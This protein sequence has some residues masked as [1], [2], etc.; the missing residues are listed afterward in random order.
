MVKS[1]GLFKNLL[2]VA[3]LPDRL[4][5]TELP[6]NLN[7]QK[8]LPLA[9]V[10]AGL[11]AI[12][13]PLNLLSQQRFHHD[14]ALYA[15]WALEIASGKNVWLAETL[16]DKP[17]L[18]IYTLAGSMW[19]L[20]RTETAARL[21][22][23][24]A[25]AGL[26]GLT[27]W[28]GCKLYGAAVGLLAAWL[29]TVSPFTIL[30]APT[31]FTDPLL[32]ALVLASGVAAARGRAGWAGFWLGLAIA[33]KQQ[34]IFFGPLVVGLMI[35][36]GDR[37][38]V[39]GRRWQVAGGRSQVASGRSQVTGG[40]WQVPGD[41]W[42]VA[43]GRSQ[44]VS[45]R[46]QVTGG[47]WRASRFTLHAPRSSLHALRFMLHALLTFLLM[48]LLTL[49]PLFIWEAARHQS[50][51]LWQLSLANYGGLTA[52]AGGFSER[53]LG[54]LELLQFGTASPV[55]NTLFLVGLPLLLLYDL[56]QIR[57]TLSKKHHPSQPTNLPPV[58][59][60]QLTNQPTTPSYFDWLLFLFSLA[61]LLGHAWLSFQVWD[62]Y[63]LGLIPL[64]ALLLARV[65]LWP[66]SILKEHWLNR[67]PNFQSPA[68]F[69][70]ALLLGGLLITTMSRPVQ[71]AV[72]GRYP[73]GSHSQ[74][75]HGI[76]QIV[77]YLQ[78]HIGANHTLYHHWLGPHWRFYLWD[79]PYDLQYW[80]SP[81]ELA[82]RAKPGHLIAF[83]S[84]QS[85]T[86][87]RLALAGAGLELRELT[88][89]YHPL[90]YPTIILYQLEQ[91]S[92]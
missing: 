23:L 21:P 49:I 18:F 1:E 17:P 54:F 34:G 88:R 4:P 86:L 55:L 51:G 70:V 41:R 57:P 60:S 35:V 64:L 44:V 66:W 43:S 24:L 75:L 79:Y 29:V 73:L 91:L 46:W 72:N 2:K 37:S 81:E 80:Q 82:A 27:F 83:P 15:T 16:I 63:L 85:D 65:L 7:P 52:N 42:Q 30:F 40:R 71:D 92:K 36:A 62:R 9:V 76:D 3:R 13:L 90:G 53:W 50:P 5:G 58:T 69:V 25:T 26:V 45:G 87:A 38:Q 59:A 31:A 68:A 10:L 56:W 12:L 84:W 11:I 14:E 33:T 32:V 67:R 6:A 22:S 61:Y 78:G 39:A 48:L 8:W 47:K 89:A 19:L 77:A 28:L 20:G 74:A